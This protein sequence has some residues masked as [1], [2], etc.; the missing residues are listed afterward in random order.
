MVA[1]TRGNLNFGEPHEKTRLL[2][3]VNTK[4]GD[5]TRE[6]KIGG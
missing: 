6:K 3:S 4:R 1:H 2:I 5:Y